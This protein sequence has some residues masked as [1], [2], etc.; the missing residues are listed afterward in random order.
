MIKKI[1]HDFCVFIAGRFG[2]NQAQK[3]NVERFHFA[4]D[5]VL[6]QWWAPPSPCRSLD[7]VFIQFVPVRRSLRFNSIRNNIFL[8]QFVHAD[9]IVP[10]WPFSVLAPSREMRRKTKIEIIKLRDDLFTNLIK[11]IDTNKTK[12]SI[13][14]QNHFCRTPPVSKRILLYG[15]RWWQCDNNNS[16]PHAWT[17]IYYQTN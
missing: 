3:L 13:Y 7:S 2:I 8:V 6:C 11:L 10:S 12:R 16:R 1:K 15:G 4:I 17:S 5:I 9:S 14:S